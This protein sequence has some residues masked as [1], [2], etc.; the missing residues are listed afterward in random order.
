M[1]KQE[2]LKDVLL[3]LVFILI[4]AGNVFI[5]EFSNLDEIWNYNFARNILDGLLPYKDFNIIITPLFP[6]IGALFLKLFGNEMIVIRF[7]ECLEG[8]LILLLIYK[9]LKRLKVNSSIAV[10]YTIFIYL[11]NSRAF[12]FDYNW[13]VLLVTL[14]ILYTELKNTEQII[15]FRFKRELLIGILARS[16]NPFKTNIR[17]SVISSSCYI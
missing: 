14:I 12:C 8:A 5:Q 1:K 7:A 11:L 10:M 17:N 2:I 15:D 13:A 3:V 4:I 6:Y 16:I 9:I